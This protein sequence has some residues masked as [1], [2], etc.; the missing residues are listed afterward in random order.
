MSLTKVSYSMIQGAVSNVLDFGATGDGVA[1]DTAFIQSAIDS[2]IATGGAVYLPKGSYK[3]TS[4]LEI[5]YGV[6]IFGDGATASKLLC[7]SCNA[8]NFVSA[9]YDN[10]KMF[11]QD[12][13]MEG[14]TGSTANW[15]AVE[16]ILPAGG[17]HGVDSRDGLNFNRLKIRNFNRGFIVS[18]LWNSKISDCTIS[19]VNNGVSVGTYTLQLSL[20]DNEFI[21]ESGDDFSGTADVYC[22][23]CTGTVVEHFY[24]SNNLLY[25]YEKAIVIANAVYVNLINNDIYATVVGIDYVTINNL[26]NITG[27]YIQFDGN[28]AIGI[29]ANGLATE[30]N[31][32]N[33]IENNIF[34]SASGTTTIGLQING[35]ANTNAFY[36]RIVG[37]FFF[38]LTGTDIVLNGPGITTVENNKCASSGT[39]QSIS[40]SSVIKAPVYV[41]RNYFFK[42]IFLATPTDVTDGTLV[43]VDNVENNVYNPLRQSA[44]PTTGTWRVSDIVWNNAPAAGQPPG[45]V[46]TVA[47]TPGTWKAMANLV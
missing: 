17:T 2:L 5:P 38:G 34:I 4:A 33:N 12:F 18:D 30:I 15:S 8:L 42:P 43:L 29:Y 41:Q 23:Q 13:G 3:I 26:L 1:D 9:S 39:T 20:V 11:Y 22:V 6:S 31:S 14:A 40:I 28:S 7:L 16:C 24:V 21:Y 10:G 44:A 37:N 19:K 46:C 36:N 27:N 32:Q 25:G 45:W 47:G 35:P